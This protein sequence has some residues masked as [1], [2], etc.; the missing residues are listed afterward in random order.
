MGF[1]GMTCDRCHRLGDPLWLVWDLPDLAAEPMRVCWR[2][3]D[4]A[5]R[6]RLKVREANKRLDKM[7][8]DAI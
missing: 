5:R 6:L 7:R 1:A 3:A 8:H 2:C 4:E